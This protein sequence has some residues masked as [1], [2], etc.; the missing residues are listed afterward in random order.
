[1]WRLTW[2]WERL[3]P[4][5]TPLQQAIMVCKPAFKSDGFQRQQGSKTLQQQTKAYSA[6]SA[7]NN[8]QKELRAT[9]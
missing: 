2:Y 8:R 7:E 1:M 3:S 4:I 6:A 9:F 5:F